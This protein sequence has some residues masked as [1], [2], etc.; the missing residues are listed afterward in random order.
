MYVPKYF[1]LQIPHFLAHFDTKTL[2]IKN[3]ADYSWDT[4]TSA[5]EEFSFIW[6]ILR[7]Q[8]SRG[9]WISDRKL[10]SSD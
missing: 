10:P 8:T 5:K 1:A 2:N 7:L 6:A 4:I 3:I 9:V